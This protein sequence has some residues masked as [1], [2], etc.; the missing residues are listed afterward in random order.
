MRRR[1]LPSF[2]IVSRGAWLE[3]SAVWRCLDGWA[4]GAVFKLIVHRYLLE[5]E[6]SLTKHHER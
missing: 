6:G 1:R 2:G 3:V 5:W 4:R